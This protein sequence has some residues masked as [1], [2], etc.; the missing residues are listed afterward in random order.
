MAPT[1][2]A[3]KQPPTDSTANEMRRDLARVIR[4]TDSLNSSNVAE[5][6]REITR[7][8]TRAYAGVVDL[9]NDF[10]SSGGFMF[11]IDAVDASD[12]RAS[13]DRPSD[14]FD[15]HASRAALPELKQRILALLTEAGPLK[16]TDIIA[17][18]GES[19]ID[20]ALFHLRTENLISKPAYGYWAVAGQQRR[21]PNVRTC[22]LDAL[23][24]GPL[25]CREIT[26]QLGSSYVSIRAYLNVL[27]RQGLVTHPTRKLWMRTDRPTDPEHRA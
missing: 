12:A 23:A 11:T 2:L 4:L 3:T 10:S 18:L 6:K 21:V 15:W 20:R 14:R 7:L 13:D 8:V 22:I 26:E 25:S 1:I 5:R 27:L 17:A 9:S 24:T 19:K 16:T